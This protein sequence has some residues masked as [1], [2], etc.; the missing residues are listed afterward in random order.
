MELFTAIIVSL[1]FTIVAELIRPKVKPPNAKAAA[2]GDFQLPTATEDRNIPVFWGRCLLKSPNITWY[3]DLRSVPLKKKIK[4]GWFS[5]TKQTY[6][7]Q[8]RLGIEHVFAA[9]PIDAIVGYR[10]GDY[11]VPTNAY[12]TVDQGDHLDVAMNATYLFGGSS[13]NSQGEGGV[14]GTMRVY[15]GVSGH[16]A[17]EYMEAQLSTTLP[18]YDGLFRIVQ[19]RFYVGTST[20]LKSFAVEAERYPNGLGL[21][22]GKNRI[23]NDANIACIIYEILTDPYWGVGDTG[24]GGGIRVADIDLASLRA[25]GN[26]IYDEGLGVSVIKD[27]AVPAFDFI[28]ELLQYIDC[29]MF[30]DPRTGLIT[31]SLIRGGYD[32]TT[33]PL[34][35]ESIYESIKFT[36]GSWS[37][38][39][40]TLKIS[41]TDRNQVYTTR[42]VQV[43]DLA[44]VQARDGEVVVRESDKSGFTEPA[45]VNWYANRAIKSAA[46]PVAKVDLVVNRTAW[47]VKLGDP[48]RLSS[49]ALGFA[50]ALFRV[51]RVDYS[52]VGENRI[53]ISAVEDVF[54]LTSSAFL[55][56]PG[57]SWV[58]PVTA[59]QPLAY[60]DMFETPYALVAA[61]QRYISTTGVSA[62]GLDLGYDL[63]EDRAGGTAY[64]NTGSNA[65]YTPVGVLTADYS[66]ATAALDTVGFIVSA[67]KRLDELASLT[68]DDDLYAGNNI[69]RI[70]SAAGEEIIAWKTIV[71]NG[72]GTYTIKNILRAVFDTVQ[73]THAAGALVWF[74]SEN[75][76][77]LSDTAYSSNGTVTAKLPTRGPLEIL[78]LSLAVPLSLALTGRALKPYPPG[79]VKVNAISY[80]T[81]IYGDASTS[82]ALRN[83]VADST[84]GRL[85]RQDAASTTTTP[86]GTITVEVRVGGTLK[87][88][89]TLATTPY[90]YTAA[91][92]A[93]DSTNGTLTVSIR[94]IPVNGALTGNY[95]ERV[96][97][98][99]GLGMVLGQ[100]L[101]G[102]QG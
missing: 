92:R 38:T 82:W 26:T 17:N 5:S 21:T 91:M 67:G 32:V 74:I 30:T 18:R 102:T 66:Q 39:T 10:F 16:A 9:C 99:T 51:I 25:V 23:V 24:A 13:F 85:I 29:V 78:D 64:V 68:T 65:G 2:L 35:D 96:F 52:E 59:P 19:E 62:S 84:A 98:M 20:Y 89:Q 12:S 45:A 83:R 3:G 55:P 75:L 56:P 44:N 47:G 7:Y 28:N 43:Q 81:T 57:S 63:Y 33:I 48:F 86:E 76:G 6:A 72:D 8:Y 37:E 22:G 14:S 53:A 40:N 54:N 4:T 58:D 90:A 79:N 50:E 88:T 69:A 70:K 61:D 60:Q 11:P 93:A 36:R 46:Y 97:T 95:Q 34:F 49:E 94:V 1:I 73:L 101:G 15:K 31:F 80:P 42:S 87:R 41:Y 27:T 77:Q 71:D 100:Y